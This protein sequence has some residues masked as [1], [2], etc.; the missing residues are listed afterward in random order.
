MSVQ[1]GAA[2]K[3]RMRVLQKGN[4]KANGTE[5]TM[6]E[7]A[8]VEEISGYIDLSAMQAGDTVQIR[9]YVKV[10][11]EFKLYASEPYN[12][13][14]SSPALYFPKKISATGMKI[15]LQQTAGIYR[16]YP[17]AFYGGS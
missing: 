7:V 8:Q 1:I 14:Q 10:D 15:T 4:L 17:H 12:G 3:P 13:A 11:S 9:Q 6:M 16:R 2:P 5:Q